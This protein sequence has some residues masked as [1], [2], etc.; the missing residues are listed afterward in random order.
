MNVMWVKFGATLKGKT[1]FIFHFLMFL[2]TTDRRYYIL[3][4]SHSLGHGCPTTK[5]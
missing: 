3:E 2:T 4:A 5:H 1:N